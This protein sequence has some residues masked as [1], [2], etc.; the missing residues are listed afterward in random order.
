[1]VLL[2][3][4]LLG[5]LGCASRRT[6]PDQPMHI[7]VSDA[8]TAEYDTDADGRADYF[9]YRNAEGRIDTIAYDTDG[10]GRPDERISLDAIP[11]EEC[12]HFVLIVDGFA[13]RL[14]LEYYDR[15]G[16][17]YCYPPSRMVAP[18][19]T[20]TDL[21]MTQLLGTE[22]PNGFEA[23]YY[24]RYERK[25]TGGS[26]SYLQGKNMP[27]NAELDYRA[28]LLLDAIGYVMP[29]WSFRREMGNLR[30]KV[31]KFQGREFVAY[32]VTSAGLGTQGAKQGHI[33]ALE[34]LD[35][36]MAR[37]IWRHRGRVKFTVFS[38]HGH[39]YSAA[40]RVPL[41]DFLRSHG[42]R[43]RDKL[44]RPDDVVYIRFGLE[45]YA[46]F[47]TERPS[48]LAADLATAEG[49]ALA[50]YT[51]WDHV[52]VLD[53][54]GG[55]AKVYRDA[56]GYRYEIVRGDPLELRPI[57]EALPGGMAAAHS[58]EALLAATADHVYPAPLQRIWKAHFEVAKH[59]PD[60]IISLK[61]DYYSGSK[62]FAGS[63]DVAS[64]HGG[65]NAANSLAFLAGSIAPPPEVLRSADLPAVMAELLN[66]PLWPL[67]RIPKADR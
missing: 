31:D 53:D 38:D 6:W 34:E 9:T 40:K 49:V 17:A 22:K 29:A 39:T 41:E 24:D 10:D 50:S 60:V 4:V 33:E 3:F 37:L 65:L 48:E 46:S 23:V 1:M 13:Y 32:F 58:P 59:L 8:T 14:A 44:S 55:E 16:L 43:I 63:V 26:W 35:D 64:T 67:K 5:G 61:D 2:A 51:Q 54:Q 20:L 7:T 56:D 36:F 11:V 27:Y 12:R 45:T 15:G 42:W 62:G 25:L 19:P 52:V 18:Y 66:A 21:A 47:F 28:G 30:R 57:L